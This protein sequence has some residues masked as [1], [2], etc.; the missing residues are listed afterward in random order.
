MRILE[1]SRFHAMLLGV[2]LAGVLSGCHSV[3]DVPP[4]KGVATSTDLDTRSG[5]EAAYRYAKSS[6]LTGL[7]QSGG[8]F[9][10]SGLLADEFVDAA[11]LGGGYRPNVDAR[12]TTVMTQ[13]YG[14]AATYPLYYLFSA[15]ASMLLS[16]SGLFKNEP[17]DNQQIVGEAF[18]L[19]GY[20]ELF[21]AEDY[22]AGVTLDRILPGGGWEW[23]MPLTTD[24][25]FAAAEAHFDSALVYANGDQ[26]VLGL[27]NIGLARARLGR[28]HY[29]EAK[30]AASVVPTSFVYNI[31]TNGGTSS[32]NWNFYR[33]GAR[34][35]S[36][37][38]TGD[39]EG[40]N[41]MDFVSAH[42][43]R[44]LV[45]STM[46]TM[47]LN[48][49]YPGA[50]PWYYPIR[51]GNPSTMLPLDNGID[52]RLIE[53]E[54]ALQAH[55]AS[56]LTILNT[57]RTTGTY[58]RIDTVAVGSGFRYDTAWVAGTGG[59]TGLGPL[60]DPGNDAA[61]VDLLFRE[62]AFW[63]FSM[64]TRLGDLRRLVRQYDR[65][66]NTVFP[67]G[68]YA[69]GVIDGMSSYGND[70]SLTLPLQT[71]N[72]YQISNPHYQGCLTSTTEG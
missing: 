14:E 55:D 71:P 10:T 28:G 24:S 32:G 42:D 61:R 47:D 60:Q 8:L 21:F 56:W 65:A 2:A 63:L 70:V 39:R 59:F 25:M 68:I 13:Q 12:S 23:G 7:V 50:K 29:P 57:L 48:N 67:T 3:L 33:D 58:T 54:A 27:A 38:N 49:E 17:A 31:I 52:A 16:V 5:A 30:A 35:A 22:C 62:R 1:L 46:L 44:L 72:S 9:V 4:P 51:F 6:M 11:V 41:G 20:N 66:S 69:G 45:D 40:G 18:A 26:T 15:R 19:V 37:I 43:P 53:A 36:Y 64:G 34:W